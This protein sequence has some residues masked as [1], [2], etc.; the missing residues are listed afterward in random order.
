[1][2]FV[3]EKKI[4]YKQFCFISIIIISTSYINCQKSNEPSLKTVSKPIAES[5]IEKK[6]NP[7]PFL[8]KNG[9]M[10]FVDSITLK[11]I[12]GIEYEDLELFNEG[13][14]AAK[15]NNKWGYVDKK[16]NVVIPFT[17][18]YAYDF[19]NNI[20]RVSLGTKQN[21]YINKEGKIVI[22][23]NYFAFRTMNNGMFLGSWCSDINC[24]KRNWDLIDVSN[25]QDVKIIS[26]SGGF[27]DP[28]EGLLATERNNKWGFIDKYG[29][30]II[31]FKYEDAF[32]FSEGFARVK[33]N[34]IW[35]VIDR[36]GKVI[37]DDVTGYYDFDFYEGLIAVER[38][39]KWGFLDKNGNVKIEIKFDAVNNFK[40]GYA[41]V[42]IN[43]EWALINKNGNI[44]LKLNG[45]EILDYSEGLVNVCTKDGKYG[46]FDL[47][48][49]EIIKT[50]YDRAENF[51]NG[52][53]VVSQFQQTSTESGY[54]YG[55]INKKGEVVIPLIYNQLFFNNKFVELGLNSEKTNFFSDL[56]GNIFKEK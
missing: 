15:K 22:P 2:S 20:A 32:S 33:I 35:V 53:S 10:I 4:L 43:N 26:L 13:L 30:E 47:S 14:S 37:F 12:T 36:T 54:R 41:R 28:S 25:I 9:K 29:N 50:K 24:K 38:N 46:F 16:E 21:G 44:V 18:K 49:N 17:Y 23:L 1:M 5:N 7:I 34:G 8:L 52:F 31:E 40:N 42:K 39:G 6:T 27:K 56:T 55:L 51:Q 3:K 19:K 45:Y 48:G 11:P